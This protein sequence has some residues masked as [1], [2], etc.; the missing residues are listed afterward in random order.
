MDYANISHLDDDLQGKVRSAWRVLDEAIEAHGPIYVVA[1]FSGGHDSLAVTHVTAMHPAFSLV[2]HINTGIGIKQTR[3]FVRWTCEDQ[4]WLLAEYFAKE[5]CGQ[6]YVDLVVER[7]FPGP[8]HHYK[9]Y[10]RLKE[11]PLG[12]MMREAKAGEHRRSCVL[13]SSGC[14]SQESVRRMKHV[15]PEERLGSYLWTNPIHDWSKAD[16]NRYIDAWNLRRNTVVDL[17]HK[18][19]ECLCGAFAQPPEE[20]YTGERGPE[21]KELAMWFP[22]AAREIEEIEER[23]R[24]AGFP[25]NWDERQPKWFLQQKRGQKA[26]FDLTPPRPNPLCHTCDA[27][28]EAAGLLPEEGEGDE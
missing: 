5:D 23:V 20:P 16:C 6:D 25:W 21:F 12:A 15:A 2:V 19:G 28:A 1:L 10:T 8:P 4:G 22:D 24:K 13:L 18:S 7:G 3:E 14:R 9:M 17:I 26:M 11:R 27:D